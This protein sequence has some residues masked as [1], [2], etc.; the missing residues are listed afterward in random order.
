MG[1]GRFCTSLKKQKKS[2]LNLVLS[3]LLL[4]LEI[5]FVL[6]VYFIFTF[7]FQQRL[8]DLELALSVSKLENKNVF[9]IA[10]YKSLDIVAAFS[11]GPFPLF[12]CHLPLTQLVC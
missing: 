9:S 1:Y 3:L 5:L 2:K 10:V 4:L 6:Y 12:F 7:L 8:L 11:L